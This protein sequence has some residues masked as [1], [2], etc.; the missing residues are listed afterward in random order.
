MVELVVI[1]GQV[2]DQA[3]R[4]LAYAIELCCRHIVQGNSSHLQWGCLS[5]Y[6]HTLNSIL[7]LI[8][9]LYSYIEFNPRWSPPGPWQLLLS[10]R[11]CRSDRATSTELYPL[12]YPPDM[13]LQWSRQHCSEHTNSIGQVPEGEPA[14]PPSVAAPPLAMGSTKV[15]PTA[16]APQVLPSTNP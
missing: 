6:T 10:S 4:Y 16:A 5:H 11:S 15:S 14:W 7:A 3:I 13:A 8:I 2:L 12:F 9:S 1:A